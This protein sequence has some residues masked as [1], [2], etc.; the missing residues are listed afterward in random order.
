MREASVERM[1]DAVIGA[2]REKMQQPLDAALPSWAWVKPCAVTECAPGWL[3]FQSLQE[4]DL[5]IDL[6]G[7]YFMA[8]RLIYLAF[9]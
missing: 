9:H 6:K 3:I 2:Y 7:H 8:K 5:K 1:K 4:S